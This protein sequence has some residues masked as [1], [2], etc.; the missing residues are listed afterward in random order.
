MSIFTRFI[1][2]AVCLTVAG[3]L[4]EKKEPLQGE[5]ETIFI[6]E[7]DLQPDLEEASRPI[8]LPQAILNKDWPTASGSTHHAMPP[9]ML[10]N[11]LRQAWTRSIGK[12]STSTAR[13][14][15]GPIA[16]EG[17]VFT[18][19]TRGLV[20]AVNLKNGSILWETWTIPEQKSSQPLSGGLAYEN[21]IVFCATPAA[22]VVLLDAQ[23]GKILRS[24]PLTAP[25]R[26]A[27]T[28]KNGVVFA[29]TINNQLEVINYKTGDPVWSHSGILETAG[30]LGGSSPAISGDVVIVPYTSGEV[31]ALRIDNGT[32]LWSESLASFQRLDPVSSLFHIKA[33]PVIEGDTVYLISHGGQMKALDLYTGETTW[34]KEIGGIRSPAV[35]G[36]YLFMVTLQN[37][38]TCIDR[39]TGKVLWVNKLPLF[40]NP[41]TKEKKFLWAG[42]VLANDR[43]VVSGSNET[44]LV[45][46]AKD[47]R[48]LQTLNLP[49][50]GLLSP[51][52]ADQTLVFLTNNAELVA[53]R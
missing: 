12:G 42:P 19:D 48:L 32:V 49:G 2:L 50:E 39:L 51:I 6:E 30:L 33:R 26:I 21:G 11:K 36:D 38:L 10:S 14:L 17:K 8:N 13:L 25:V 40:N 1:L 24:F 44:A 7:Y 45:L 43:L 27:P 35:A 46:S 3:C 9:L 34:M 41:T 29:V 20:T 47:G 31:Y 28:V 22:E 52:I 18:V 37:D 5:R 23:N 15:N 4:K 16:A 53:Y